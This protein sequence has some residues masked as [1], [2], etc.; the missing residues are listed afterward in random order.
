MAAF[1]TRPEGYYSAVFMDLNMPVLD[2]IEAAKQIR[3]SG[4][5]DAGTIPV[6]AVTANAGS[7]SIVRIHEAGMNTSVLKPIESSVLYETL[8]NYI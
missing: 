4:R 8:R 1:L 6:I 7:G 5:A 2:G 3:G